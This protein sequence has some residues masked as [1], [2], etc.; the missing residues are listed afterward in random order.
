M[1]ELI[2]TRNPKFG[3]FLVEFAT[4]GIGHIL[5]N[6]GC[7][8]VLLDLEHS[9]FGMD[10]CRSLLRYME[11]AALPAIVGMPSKDPHELARLL[12][13]GAQAV[14]SPMVESVAEA[15]TA[16]ART[17][18]APAG[19]RAVSGGVGHDKWR[20]RPLAE[21]VR[22]AKPLYFAKI[23][24]EAGVDAADEIAGMEGVDGLWIGHGDLTA[25]MGIPGEYDN[26][27][28]QQAEDRIVAAALRT[29]KP[30]GRLVDS[31]EDGLGL[32]RK[33]FRLIGYSADA[34]LLQAGLSQAIGA[35]REGTNR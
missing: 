11:A 29:D 16:V 21:T 24:T 15:E 4:P 30:A 33:G 22:D 20:G 34:W 19:Q 26:V 1:H 3:T 32:L 5:K 31:V 28:Y 2:A 8:F 18:Y 13:I 35:L 17:R 7:D 12:D 23:E 10:T 14:M 25:S 6:A 27:R 9:G